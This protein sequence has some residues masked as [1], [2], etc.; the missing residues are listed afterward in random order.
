MVELGFESLTT[1]TQSEFAQWCE[2]HAGW[3]PYHYELLNGR[4]VMTPPAGFPHGSIGA[5]VVYLLQRH[6]AEHQLGEVLESS[7]GFELPSGDTVAADASFVSRSRWDAMVAPREGRF[8]R[9][10]PDLVVEILSKT[11]ASRDRGEK[12]AIYANNGVRELWLVDPR[13]R[14]LQVFR[15]GEPEGRFD[16][17]RLLEEHEE[18][19][20]LGSAAVLPKLC[21]S[22]SELFISG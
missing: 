9:V 22:V 14:T 10:V 20:A 5:R 12:K 2:E 15:Q 8:L 4:V 17:G 7:Q 11:T 3:D 19:Q 16:A 13:A 18:Y 1:L 21:F 6:V